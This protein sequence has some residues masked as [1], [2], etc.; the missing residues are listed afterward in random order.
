MN[1]KHNDTIAQLGNTYFAWLRQHE[2]VAEEFR[3][4]LHELMIDAG[5]NFDRVDVRIKSWP[6]LKEKAKKRRG[7]KIVYPDP[8]NDIRD[9]IGARITVMHSTEIPAVLRLLADQFDVLRSVDKAQETRVSG[10]FGYGSHHLVLQVGEHNEELEHYRGQVFEVQVRTVLQHAWAEFEHDVRY[11]R[12]HGE[13]DPQIDRAFTLA[14]GLIELAD[15]Q[16]DQIAELSNPQKQSPSAPDTT[17]ALTPE[18]LPGVLTVIL[19][20]SF[21]LSRVDDYRFLHEL[22]SADGIETVSALAEL[23]NPADIEAVQ[24]TL[25]TRFTP[26]QVRL[27]DD[28]LLNKFGQEHINRTWESGN[29]PLLRKRKLTRRL[30]QLREGGAPQINSGENA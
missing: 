24:N 26:G 7:G 27:V 15:Q 17:A 8:W 23:A 3:H 14:A 2:G 6:S 19:G 13:L 10:T 11:K 12:S 9:L 22:L 20:A 18:T 1:T 21:P 16:F 29:R 30:T 4:A 5:I 28:L 25:Q